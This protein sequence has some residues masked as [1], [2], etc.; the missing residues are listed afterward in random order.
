MLHLSASGKQVFSRLERALEGKASQ[1]AGLPPAFPSGLICREKTVS[2]SQTAPH[3]ANSWK[4]R[5]RLLRVRSEGF[6]QIHPCNPLTSAGLFHKAGASVFAMFPVQV[7]PD[8]RVK[9]GFAP[10]GPR[11]A[12][13][14]AS[15][16]ATRCAAGTTNM[17]AFW[18]PPSCS[19]VAPVRFFCLQDSW[20]AWSASQDAVASVCHSNYAG[21]VEVCLCLVL[22]YTAERHP[23]RPLN[24]FIIR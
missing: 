18:V 17:L 20:R 5:L 14:R 8:R 4:R 6:L 2:I 12:T 11:H 19:P 23:E 13:L 7:I 10:R 9:G 16:P 15:L 21:P 3:M 24:I 1:D 22:H